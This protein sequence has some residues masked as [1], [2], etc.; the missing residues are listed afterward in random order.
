MDCDVLIE[1]G[2]VCSGDLAPAIRAD[3][4]IKGSRIAAIGRL[5][6]NANTVVHAEGKFVAPGFIDIHSH[7]DYTLLADPRAVSAIHQG[8]TL[9]VI[10]NCGFGCAPIED[11]RAAALGIYGFDSSVPI[12]WRDFKGYFAALEAA[13]PA[14]N[15]MSLAPAGQI[16]RAAGIDLQR[17]AAESERHRLVRLLDKCMGDGCC[18]FSTGLEYPVER[19]AD[20]VEVTALVRTTAMHGGFYATH[21]RARGAG[22]LPAIDE[23]IRTARAAR[24]QLQISHIIPRSTDHGEIEGV[25]ERVETARRQDVN[26]GFD[27]HT[28]TFGTTMLN[29]LLPPWVTVNGDAERIRILSDIAARARIRSFPSIIT[30]LGDWSR[31]LLL[32]MPPWP[33]YG[34]KSVAQV[35]EMRG[36]DPFDAALDLLVRETEGSRPFMVLLSCYTEAQQA[37]FFSHPDCI[38]ASDAT[39]LAPDGPLAEAVFHG[40]YSWAAWFYRFMVRERR[41]ITPEEA[42]H[43]LTG[44]PAGVLGLRERGRLVEGQLADIVVFDPESYSE[45]AGAFTPNQLA[46]G[47]SDLF[48][49]GVHTV[50]G[51][52]ATGQRAGIVIRGRSG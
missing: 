40:A 5:S 52:V 33:D 32:D 36:Q 20:E 41:L 50:C 6:S 47:V 17:P 31:V 34:R 29:T 28:R 14:V 38:P 4:A 46:S 9:E 18:G 22:A 1:G 51:G 16:R 27:M 35:A 42:V 10:G 24:A 45:R 30:S 2:M 49:N 7:S 11:P 44:K 37:A 12:N 39:T 8:V 26:V 23:A 25:L 15:V 21:T 3:V 43:R 48:V 13:R 19:A